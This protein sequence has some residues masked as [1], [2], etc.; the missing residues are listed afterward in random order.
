MEETVA[1]IKSCIISKKGGVAMEDLNDEFEILVGESIPY[2]RLGFASLRALLR[3][4]DGLEITWNNFG[5]QVLKINDSKISHINRLIRKQKLDYS[6]TRDK[7]Y[8]QFIRN[9]GNIKNNIDERRERNRLISNNNRANRRN[10]D[11]A[12]R[13]NPNLY[14][15]NG[16]NKNK[17]FL[18]G[19]EENH[20]PV[21]IETNEVKKHSNVYEPVANGRQLIGD[22]FFLQLA[23]RNLHLPIWRCKKDSL[24]L[25]CGLCVSGQTISDC[26]RALKNITTIS[27]RVVIL[28]GS[29]DVY[30]NATCDE[31][32][33]DMTELLQVLRSKFHL[34]NTAITICTL[35]PLANL[36]I[37]AYKTQNLALLSFNNWIRSLADDPAKR[38]SSFVNY[39][40]IDLYQQYCGENFITNYDLFQI[41]ARR[42]SGTK[43][44]YVLW[45]LQGRQHAMSLIYEDE[46]I[47][48]PPGSPSSLS[49]Q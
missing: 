24:A 2:R 9:D 16:V 49:V 13:R 48:N 19:E 17:N 6:K 44:S 46:N 10:L 30:N 31:M 1:L 7:Y 42:V 15:T 36:G 27:N 21:V 5:E 14:K 45:N 47:I 12:C 11:F 41:Q 39:S 26:T 22:D 38:D 18:Y 8:K 28:L 35:P 29:V 40:V 34:S 33:R 3:T 25:H 23:I 43:H 37:H 4:I 20:Y 32:I